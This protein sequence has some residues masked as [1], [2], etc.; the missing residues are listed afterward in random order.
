MAVITL[1]RRDSMT[2]RE[3]VLW[4]REPAGVPLLPISVTPRIYVQGG[5]DHLAAFIQELRAE[6]RALGVTAEIV[7]RGE[8]YDY[9]I[10]FVQDDSTAAAIA[11]DRQGVL[12]A[13]AVDAAFRVRSATEG[14][15]RRLVRQMVPAPR[16]PR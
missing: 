11:L 8:D 9:T 10:V 2:V 3:F 6:L 5:F 4:I 7:Q 14:V 16:N 12:I 13:S 1:L 15:A